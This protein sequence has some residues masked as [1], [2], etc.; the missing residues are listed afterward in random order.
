MRSGRGSS[1]CHDPSHCSL[2]ADYR[3]PTRSAAFVAFGKGQ[4]VTIEGQMTVERSGK[5]EIYEILRRSG[6]KVAVLLESQQEGG[7]CILLQGRI[8][9]PPV[10]P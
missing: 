9:S 8:L 2:E 3:Y 7:A 10:A 6:D 4:P 5:A 1:C